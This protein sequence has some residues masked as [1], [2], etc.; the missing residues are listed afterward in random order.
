MGPSGRGKYGLTLD[1]KLWESG[2]HATVSCGPKHDL[3]LNL[4]APRT[5]QKSD[6]FP[7]LLRFAG[8]TQA[9]ALPSQC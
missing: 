8:R 6:E 3:R 9:N 1:T 2:D 4:L 7:R 5:T